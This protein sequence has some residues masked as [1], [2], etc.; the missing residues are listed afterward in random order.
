MKFVI[1]KKKKN[2]IGLTGTII[3]NSKSIRLANYDIYQ[4]QR[5]HEIVCL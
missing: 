3:Y 1:K 2:I 4:V 5:G